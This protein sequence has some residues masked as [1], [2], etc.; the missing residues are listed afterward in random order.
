VG[1]STALPGLL[2]VVVPNLEATGPESV[3]AAFAV[4]PGGR[5]AYTRA[6]RRD[7]ALI[8]VQDT[9]GHEVGAL[10]TEGQGPGELRGEP[11]LNFVGDD[12]VV[13]MDV[14][15]MRFMSFE[16]KGKHEFTTGSWRTL[17]VPVRLGRDSAD[18]SII[19]V[20]AR[21]MR[22]QSIAR[23]AYKS[24]EHREI[25]G[26]QDSALQALNTGLP[27]VA[28]TEG[29]IILGNPLTFEFVRYASNEAPLGWKRNVPPRYP[30][31][32]EMDAKLAALRTR[33]GT[34]A[35]GFRGSGSRPTEGEITA[36]RKEL[37]ATPQKQFYAMGIDGLRRLWTV[38]QDS[39]GAF[40]DVFSDTTHLGRVGI[41]CR[42]ASWQVSINGRWFAAMCKAPESDAGVRLQLFR[43]EG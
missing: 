30:T 41:P 5:L 34:L 21:S 25:V 40:A 4:S 35:P 23:V 38:S 7:G 27:L 2:S 6:F 29:I 13:A 8:T 42:L 17:G 32:S 3:N 19:D 31:E 16:A 22:L 15:K 18:V 24:L 9:A 33:G 39:S 10:A 28:A 43:I 20:T 11:F 37:S 1:G 26:T 36:M 12:I 14:G